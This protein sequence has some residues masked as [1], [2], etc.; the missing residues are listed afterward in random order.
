M[1]HEYE[2]AG[3]S[4]ADCPNDPLELFDR[5]LAEAVA[6]GMIEPNAMAVATVDESGAPSVRHL[7]LKGMSDGGFEFYTNYTSRKGADLVT[8][9]RV[10]LVFPWL[11]LHRQVTVRGRADRVT[12][13][14]S[15]AYFAVRPRSS[16]LGAWVSEQSSLIDGR[17]EL[18]TREREMEERFPDVVPRPPHWGGYRVTPGEIEFWQGRPSRLHDRIVYLR[19]DE[20]TWTRH[21]RAP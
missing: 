4:E 11:D 19:T 8:E 3:L 7:L 12:D 20:G 2:M 14:E 16:Q 6:A 5:W 15:D 21:R 10:A 9:P 17:G 18:A 1:R 13:E